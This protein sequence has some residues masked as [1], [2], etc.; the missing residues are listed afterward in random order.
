MKI[1]KYFLIFTFCTVSIIGLLYG[2]APRWFALTLLGVADLDLDF[3]HILRAIMCLYLA[4]GSFW[5]FAAFRDEHIAVLSRIEY[6]LN[7]R[8]SLLEHPEFEVYSTQSGNAI[9]TRRC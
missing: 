4:L 7:R 1:K 5:L 9:G 8:I 6:S 3:V 2:V